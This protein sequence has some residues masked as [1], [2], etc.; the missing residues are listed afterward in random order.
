MLPTKFR[1]AISITIPVFSAAAFFGLIESFLKIGMTENLMKTG[2]TL[3][4]VLGI[5]NIFAAYLVVKH[6][7]P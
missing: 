3:A 7:V 2:A 5:L 4:I 1:R 6:Q